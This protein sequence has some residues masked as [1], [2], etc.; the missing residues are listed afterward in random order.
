VVHELITGGAP[1]FNHPAM[2]AL[3]H[4]VSDAHPPL[5]DNISP[6]RALSIISIF[7]FFSPS[8]SPQELGRFPPP[9]LA[10][11]PTEATHG[12]GNAGASVAAPRPTERF[13]GL[14]NNALPLLCTPSHQRRLLRVPPHPLICPQQEELLQTARSWIE[15]HNKG[16]QFNSSQ[17]G[18]GR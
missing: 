4:I 1:Y 10:K 5:P 18:D 7:L 9:M 8:S 2:A 3:F 11:G 6:V 12:F 13:A 15:D 17:Q 14:G 16:Q